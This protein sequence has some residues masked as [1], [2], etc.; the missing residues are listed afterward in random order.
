MRDISQRERFK[1]ERDIQIRETIYTERDTHIQRE[2]EKLETNRPIQ[3]QKEREVRDNRTIQIKRYRDRQRVNKLE[4]K[5][6]MGYGEKENG[7]INWYLNLEIFAR[8]HLQT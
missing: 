7:L 8:R 6:E 1:L 5:S 4:R 3:I 2:K